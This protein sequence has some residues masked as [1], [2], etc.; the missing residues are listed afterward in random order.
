MSFNFYI[1]KIKFWQSRQ[2]FIKVD[3]LEKMSI[4]PQVKI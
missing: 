3:L 4:P 1:L 2:V